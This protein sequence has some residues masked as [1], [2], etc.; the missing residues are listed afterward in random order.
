LSFWKSLSSLLLESSSQSKRV[1]VRAL[2]NASTPLRIDPRLPETGNGHF[3]EYSGIQIAEFRQMTLIQRKDHSV[4]FILED[5]FCACSSS[6]RF[7]PRQ[8]I[9]F[10]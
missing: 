1:D 7:V 5:N 10:P 6:R 2:D 3:D 8:R 9:A 4:A